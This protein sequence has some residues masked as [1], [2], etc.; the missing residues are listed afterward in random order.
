M[1]FWSTERFRAQQGV[2]V[3]TVLIEREQINIPSGQF[4]LLLTEEVISVPL[5]AIAFISIRAVIKFQGLVNVSGFHVDPGFSGRL[6]IAV[7]NSGG[8]DIT[9]ERGERIFLIWLSDLDQVTRDPYKGS[10]MGQEAISADDVR[11][12]HGDIASPAVLHSEI[13]SIQVELKLLWAILVA[14]LLAVLVSLLRDIVSSQR[15]APTSSSS[16]AV[17]S[18]ALRHLHGLFHC[19]RRTS[20]QVLHRLCLPRNNPKW[21]CS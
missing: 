20:P 2:Q 12:L 15:A 17:S 6:T 9:L 8:R 14:L 13:K 19:S 7:Y 16:S 3:K 18:R 21:S 4:A 5:N 11:K 10:R 1:P